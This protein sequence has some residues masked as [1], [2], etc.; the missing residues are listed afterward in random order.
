MKEV[1]VNSWWNNIDYVLKEVQFGVDPWW[2]NYF[3]WLVALSAFFFGMELIKPWRTKQAAFRKHFWLDLFYMFFNFSIFGV[4]IFLAASLD[5]YF[6]RGPLG[7]CAWGGLSSHEPCE[8]RHKPCRFPK[9]S[10]WSMVRKL[11]ANA[12]GHSPFECSSQTPP[13]G[14]LHRSQKC[15]ARLQA[16]AASTQL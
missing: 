10:H 9:S 11:L 7:M 16:E 12:L 14:A 3:W 6:D 15:A 5:H 1:F 2:H 13:T 4:V 8:N